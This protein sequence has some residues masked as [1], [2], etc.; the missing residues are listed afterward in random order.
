[1][2]PIDVDID[3]RW[4]DNIRSIQWSINNIVNSTTSEIS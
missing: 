4:D 1:L 3:K 2:L